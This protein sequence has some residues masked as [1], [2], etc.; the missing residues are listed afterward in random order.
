MGD[1]VEKQLEADWQEEVENSNARRGVEVERR[2]EA[3]G[4]FGGGLE[5]QTRFDVETKGQDAGSRREGGGAHKKGE[6]RTARDVSKGTIRRSAGAADVTGG[7]ARRRAGSIDITGRKGR[8][9]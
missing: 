5:V 9:G 6:A 7:M 2:R 8:D 1:D 4:A 3:G